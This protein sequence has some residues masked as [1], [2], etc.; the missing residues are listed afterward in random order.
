MYNRIKLL[1]VMSFLVGLVV[2]STLALPALA[3]RGEKRG[4]EGTVLIEL[5]HDNAVS[6]DNGDEGSDTYTTI[7]VGTAWHFS[8]GLSLNLMFVLEP[9][10]DPAFNEDR[11]FD[12]LGGYAEELFIKYERGRFAIWAGKFNPAFGLAWDMAPGIY[13]VDFAEDYEL[14]EKLGFGAS[15]ALGN[16]SIGDATVTAALFVADRSQLSQSLFTRRGRLTRADGG[17]SN[18]SDLDSFSVALDVE[19]L[20]GS[21]VNGHVA[22]RHQAQGETRLDVDDETGIVASLYGERELGRGVS[23]SWIGEVAFI[24]HFDATSADLF[25]YTLGAEFSFD[26]YHVAVS[27]TGRDVNDTGGDFDDYLF[28]VSAGT[29]IYDGWGLDVGYRLSEEENEQVHIVGVLFAKEFE[30]S[31]K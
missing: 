17:A 12:D 11:F 14:T 2:S 21:S 22:Y 6:A 24:E 15:F 16:S 10:L 19:K 30:F 1:K 5:Q 3:E 25:Y 28:Q 20:F 8:R 29:E 31:H 9:V 18:T 7:E 4:I 26:R 27:F 13:G 23:V